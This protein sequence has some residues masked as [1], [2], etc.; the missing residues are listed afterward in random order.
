MRPGPP[1][2]FPHRL[3]AWHNASTQRAR[4]G[5]VAVPT[6]RSAHAKALPSPTASPTRIGAPTCCP[7]RAKVLLVPRMTPRRPTQVSP[8][9]VRF[10]PKPTARAP[11]FRPC[12]RRAVP[13]PTRC[14]YR[15]VAPLASFLS[16]RRQGEDIF[17][18]LPI[19]HR[20][21]YLEHRSPL[22]LTAPGAAA[23]GPC[24]CLTPV[25]LRHPFTSQLPEPKGPFP[26]NGTA[27]MVFPAAKDALRT[28]A[29]SGLRPNSPPPL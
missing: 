22:L 13:V 25:L 18:P 11:A 6:I 21:W 15:A 26:F 5:T 1:R 10:R 2:Q 27:W 24:C 17:S 20:D 7:D 12:R 19:P 3:C 28:T 16:T 8:M 29:Y 14:R 4:A 23:T 9:P